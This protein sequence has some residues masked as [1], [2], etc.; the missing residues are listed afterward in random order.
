MNST[1]RKVPYMGRNS[2]TGTVPPPPP[3]V[4]NDTQT[5]PVCDEQCHARVTVARVLCRRL[6]FAE[7]KRTQPLITMLVERDCHGIG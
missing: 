5:V 3:E 2:A 6:G 1:M 4:D 7:A